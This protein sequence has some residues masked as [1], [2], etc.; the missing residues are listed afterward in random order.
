M[1]NLSDGDK[2]LILHIALPMNEDTELMA[3]DANDKFCAQTNTVFTPGN[4]HYTSIHLEAN[5]QAK[6]KDALMHYRQGEMKCCWKKPSGV[7]SMAPLA[8]SLEFTG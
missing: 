6:A 5:E 8:I 1:M 7:R 2:N 4:S 3:S